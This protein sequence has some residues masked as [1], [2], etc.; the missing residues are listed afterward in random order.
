MMKKRSLLSFM[1]MGLTIIVIALIIIFGGTNFED[2]GNALKN[3][4]IWWMFA[5]VG[6]LLLYWLTDGFLLHDITSYMYKSE[7]FL[8]SLKIGIIGLYYCAL[9]PSSTG[10]QPAQVVYMRRNKIPVGTATCIVGI[11]FVVF[12]LSLCTI[13]I[14]GIIIKLINGEAFWNSETFWLATLGFLINMAAVFF[15]ILTIVNRRLVLNLGN[16]IIRALSKIR[17]I[18]K[19]EK[20]QMHFVNTIDDYHTAASYISRYKLRAFGSYLISIVNLASLFLIPLLIY[21][22]FGNKGNLIEI[23]IMETFLFLA[24]SFFPLP[25]AAVASEGGFMLFFSYF[26]KDPSDPTKTAVA[27]LT[28]AMLIWRFLTYYLLL[29]VGSVLVVLDEVFSL[30]RARKDPELNSSSE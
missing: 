23:F 13:F 6:A 12:E 11:K 27:M 25:G 21:L 1:Y 26:F 5:C 24:V 19:K 3:F 9:T 30:R 28:V 22:S 17:I 14:A 18:K 4:N 7:S 15:I 20:A 2:I 8:Q 10:G 29:I 16:W